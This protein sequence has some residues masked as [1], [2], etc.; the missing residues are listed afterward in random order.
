MSPIL[1]PELNLSK[2]RK[3]LS[4]DTVCF[5]WWGLLSPIQTVETR[6]ADPWGAG[7]SAARLGPWGFS[8]GGVDSLGEFFVWINPLDITA[9]KKLEYSRGE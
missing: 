1:S 5:F 8:T 7:S 6:T 3:I 2:F 9:L 4:F